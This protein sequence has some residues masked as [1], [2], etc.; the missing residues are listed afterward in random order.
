MKSTEKDLFD[1]DDKPD[2]NELTLDVCPGQIVQVRVREGSDLKDPFSYVAWTVVLSRRG[3]DCVGF[4]LEGYYEVLDL[5]IIDFQVSHVLSIG[6]PIHVLSEMEK[7]Q[8]RM[9][10]D[11]GPHE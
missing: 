2:T 5:Q 3:N 11:R 9:A 8:Y 1:L 10:A 6:K 7:R 4:G